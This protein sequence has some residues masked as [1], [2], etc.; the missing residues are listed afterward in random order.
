VVKTK[1]IDFAGADVKVYP[2]PLDES[3]QFEISGVP[4]A[5]F[6]LELYD[7]LGK[8]VFNQ[9]YNHSTF[10]LYRNQ[11]PAGMLFYRLITNKGQPVASGKL[12]VK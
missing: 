12:L 7:M 5:G 6:N 2:N 4:A 11:L 1:H 8:K 9:S 10:R 3:A